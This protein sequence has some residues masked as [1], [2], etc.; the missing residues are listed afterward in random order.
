MSRK[1]A[2]DLIA[3]LGGPVAVL[4]TAQFV[5]YSRGDSALYALIAISL[6]LGAASNWWRYERD[7]K[8]PTARNV[9]NG[10]WLGTIVLPP[11]LAL[12]QGAST[13]SFGEVLG[14]ALVVGL[15][16]GYVVG[17]IYKTR[18]EEKHGAKP[19]RD[20]VPQSAARHS[21]HAAP[22]S[23]IRKCDRIEVECPY[24]AELILAKARFCKHCHRDVEPQLPQ[25]APTA[26]SLDS[27]SRAGC[28]GSA[29]APA[30][31]PGTSTPSRGND[32]ADAKAE[33]SQAHGEAVS[34]EESGIR[35]WL[36]LFVAL[37]V[38]AAA[39]LLC[40]A[41]ISLYV[42]SLAG[43]GTAHV[44]GSLASKLAYMAAVELALGVAIG[45]GLRWTWKR[46]ARAPKFWSFFLL[47]IVPI[48]TLMLYLAAAIVF[49]LESPGEHAATLERYVK[50][51][52]WLS[53]IAA[54]WL[55]YWMRSRR[56]LAT[57][58]TVGFRA[59]A[60]H[61]R[62]QSRR[63]ELMSV[64][65]SSALVLGAWVV[66]IGAV[67]WS[68]SREGAL[69]P[70]RQPSKAVDPFAGM[71]PLYPDSSMD[72]SSDS[73]TNPFAFLGS[74]VPAANAAQI[75]DS[76]EA[77]RMAVV[78]RARV[79]DLDLYRLLTR[80]N[81]RFMRTY[82]RRLRPVAALLPAGARQDPAGYVRSHGDEIAR[83]LYAVDDTVLVRLAFASGHLMQK[84]NSWQC[85]PLVDDGLAAITSHELFLP[86]LEAD[87]VEQDWY[88]HGVA[89][90]LAAA[91]SDAPR[92][93]DTLAMVR[94]ARRHFA[95]RIYQ[96]D[97]DYVIRVLE[98]RVDRGK[99]FEQCEAALA[100]YQ[101]VAVLPIDEA[102]A[103]LRSIKRR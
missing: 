68:L 44:D 50:E 33:R 60:A 63:P 11:L 92:H 25:A 32:A 97:A 27:G 53:A 65:G 99:L 74:T 72:G 2:G 20:N 28:A 22:T 69:A 96:A 10:A 40:A 37:Q 61:T 46:D 35:G 93:V 87:S 14:R 94:R 91:L 83:G 7:G 56:V 78:E 3:V 98:G 45:V 59:P 6:A 82:E 64:V 58:G 79:T 90:S 30:P 70:E 8:Q 88:A 31:L 76:A 23:Y 15:F 57:F 42:V 21:S 103:L 67:R 81:A 75:P 73:S 84:L 19:V 71:T 5:V 89:A 49:R 1:N 95:E 17:V 100:F 39:V 47:L 48:W 26:P 16:A 36:A 13:Y 80:P 86:A 12:L 101:Q 38:L 55:G 54:I 41:P 9:R 51:V 77:A 85:G 62:D 43:R 4:V 29:P 34:A 102:A 24:C 66:L 18:V 52:L